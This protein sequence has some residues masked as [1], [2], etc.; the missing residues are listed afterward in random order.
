MITPDIKEKEPNPPSHSEWAWLAET[1]HFR[2]P[3]L[4]DTDSTVPIEL[5]VKDATGENVDALIATQ[6]VVDAFAFGYLQKLISHEVAEYF[7]L[8]SFHRQGRPMHTVD[9]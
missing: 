9:T 5:P 7:P 4:N 6:K 8:F 3:G 1:M 2:A